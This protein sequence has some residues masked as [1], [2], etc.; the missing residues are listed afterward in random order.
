MAE[1]GLERAIDNV[2]WPFFFSACFAGRIKPAI[3]WSVSGSD[4]TAQAADED[5]DDDV[6]DEEVN[7]APDGGE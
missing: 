2:S 6:V 1:T 5:D 4:V 7:L 3:S